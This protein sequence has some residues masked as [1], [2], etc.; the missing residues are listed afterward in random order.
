MQLC[1]IAAS[2]MEDS[3]QLLLFDSILSI[4]IREK[5]AEKRQ[6]KEAA[7]LRWEEKMQPLRRWER[8]GV[9]GLIFGRSR[10]VIFPSNSSAF[11]KFEGRRSSFL[12]P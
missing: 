1:D 9:E 3:L 10:L 11:P 6:K 2:A 5:L 7:C 12:Y 8:P 4:Y